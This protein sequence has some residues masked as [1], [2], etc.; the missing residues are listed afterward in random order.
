MDLAIL[1]PTLGHRTIQIP[2]SKD[3]R[4]KIEKTIYHVPSNPTCTSMR[5]NEGNK[6][7]IP[8]NLHS[9]SFLAY[10]SKKFITLRGN[11]SAGIQKSKITRTIHKS[12]NLGIATMK[13][14]DKKIKG[15]GLRH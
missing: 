10:T 15:N 8:S 13:I 11:K 6:I 14:F 2:L 1:K 7:R 3:N 4:H 12:N 5:R 9:S